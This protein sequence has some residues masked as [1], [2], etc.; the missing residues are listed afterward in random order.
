MNQPLTVSLDL[1]LWIPT[2]SLFQK[3]FLS[4]RVLHL[5]KG[6]VLPTGKHCPFRKVEHSFSKSGI[7]TCRGEPLMRQADADQG[8]HA[9]LTVYPSLR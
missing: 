9:L 7:S 2:W 5:A 8:V 6:S 4:D 1:W 3:A